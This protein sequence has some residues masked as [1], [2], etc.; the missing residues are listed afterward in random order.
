[1]AERIRFHLDEHVP[2]AVAQG[3]RRR[4]VDVT[5]TADVGLLSL[6]DQVQLEYARKEQRVF[7]THDADFLRLHAH[8]ASHYGIVYGH[9]G[10]HTAGQIIRTLLLIYELLSPAEMAGRVEFL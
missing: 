8:G 9:Q 1:M 4:G 10:D 6:D 3:L 2:F 5:T 7:V